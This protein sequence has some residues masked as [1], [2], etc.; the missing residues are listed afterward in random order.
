MSIEQETTTTPLTETDWTLV[1]L[2]DSKTSLSPDEVDRLMYTS[3]E[4]YR[5]LSRAEM[6]QL[7][8][9]MHNDWSLLNRRGK[10]SKRF[11]DAWYKVFHDSPP[12][13]FVHI[14]AH[15]QA[16]LGGGPVYARIQQRLDWYPSEYGEGRTSCY[17]TYHNS[18]RAI[19]T[20]AGTHGLLIRRALEDSSE[21]NGYL[22]GSGS[23]RSFLIPYHGHILLR[24]PYGVPVQR[25][26]RVLAH[27]LGEENLAAEQ[28]DI[29]VHVRINKE[30][31][32][33]AYL[34]PGHGQFVRLPEGEDV[35]APTTV[36]A[37]KACYCL[38]WWHNQSTDDSQ[39]CQHCPF[40]HQPQRCSQDE[41]PSFECYDNDDE[42][43]EEEDD[44]DWY[45]D[46][47]E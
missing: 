45:D 40:N 24:N 6:T 46:N 29:Q 33:R 41:Q 17:F 21:K 3:W 30:R 42:P 47:D 7:R 32:Q 26:L 12:Y 11:T 18:A 1:P 43:F 28:S 10:L 20:V 34:N 8:E 2:D 44:D 13:P 22:M 16:T 5:T 25:Q 19:L 14:I 15:W 35:A 23:G 38:R 37:G 31:Y 36:E 4:H 39:R 9:A 27:L